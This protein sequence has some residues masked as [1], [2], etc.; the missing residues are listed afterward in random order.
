MHNVYLIQPAHATMFE[1]HESY[2]LPYS[3]GCLWSYA[4]QN[5]IVAEN[6]NLAGLI[7]K[8]L[9]IDQ[10]ISTMDT[11][12]EAAFSCYVCNN[13]KLIYVQCH[14]IDLFRIFKPFNKE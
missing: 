10:I 6:F 1:G 7:Y 9:P 4:S 8:R 12:S 2:W 3:V 13:V 11:P 5:Q 14:S